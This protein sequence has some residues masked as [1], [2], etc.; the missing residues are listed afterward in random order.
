MVGSST[1]TGSLTS[2]SA[3]PASTSKPSKAANGVSF[4]RIGAVAVV[5]LAV[6]SALV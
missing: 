4:S 6:F 5:G 3:P 2:T 1:V